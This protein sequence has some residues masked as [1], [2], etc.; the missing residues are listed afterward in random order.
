MTSILITLVTN[1]ERLK[2]QGRLVRSLAKGKTLRERIMVIKGM[3]SGRL[4]QCGTH[5]LSHDVCDAVIASSQQRTNEEDSAQKRKYN[6]KN[7]R[8][9]KADNYRQQEFNTLANNDSKQQ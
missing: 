9:L 8:K 2:L 7:N 1:E 3:T 4:I 6:K 5:C